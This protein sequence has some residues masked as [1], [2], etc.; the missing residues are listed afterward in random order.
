MGG[1]GVSKVIS[2]LQST[3]S[4]ETVDRFKSKI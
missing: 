4:A 1:G 2:S 3:V